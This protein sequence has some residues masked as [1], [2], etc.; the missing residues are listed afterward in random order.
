MP[1]TDHSQDASALLREAFF[2]T[3]G[4]APR[5]VLA[6]HPNDDMAWPST[7]KLPE[8]Q[9]AFEY[10]RS[11]REALHVLENTLAA[12]GRRLEDVGSFLDF[13]SGFGRL[14]RHL[15]TRLPAKRIWSAD[16]MP[17]TARFN[18]DTYGVHAF[19]SA[20][21]PRDIRFERKY[22]VI[23]V[24]SLF[25]HLPPARFG[26]FLSVLAGA[27]EPDGMLIFS[28]HALDESTEQEHTFAETAENPLL[29][30]REY[31]LAW[32]AESFV[33][34][35]CGELGLRFG[36]MKRRDLWRIQDV[37]VVLGPDASEAREWPSTPTARGGIDQMICTDHARAFEGVV[38]IPVGRFPLEKVLLHVGSKTHEAEFDPNLVAA[39]PEDGGQSFG[40]TAFRLEGDLSLLPPGESAVVGEA[41]FGGGLRSVFFGRVDRA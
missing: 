3:T 7:L 24:G 15:V 31:G 38:M 40:T 39:P 1:G 19:E 25:T 5:P 12:H 2:R 8:D 10:L 30:A 18:R 37:N 34:K 20:A 32:T 23:W 41:V 27:L 33:P 26:E 11:G 29:D 35:L 28:T 4:I 36:G 6:I 13:A 17:D 16:L 21:N 22:S 9:A 14:L